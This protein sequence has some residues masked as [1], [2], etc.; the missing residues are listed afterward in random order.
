MRLKKDFMKKFKRIF[1]E[2]S[3]VCNLSCSFCPPTCR[4]A[5]VMSLEDFERV[6]KRL[7]G[8][9]DNVYLHVKGEPLLHP[10]FEGILNLCAQ[11]KKKI[12]ITTNGTLIDK[13]G[14]H[15]LKNPAVRLVSVSLQSHEKTGDDLG[16]KTYLD[17][18]LSFVKRGLKE[19]DSLFALRLWNFEDASLV[20]NGKNQKTLDYIEEFLDLSS[21]IT[22]TDP[23]TNGLK[24]PD[25]VYI[26]KGV[27]FDWPSLSHDLVAT[28][29]TCYGLRRQI[30]ILS[31]GEV[32]PCCL[33]ADGVIGL[34]NILDQSF[35]EIVMSPKAVKI[36]TSLE[37]NKL[38][39]PLC[40]RCDYRERFV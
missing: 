9:G 2:I 30:A 14:D 1:I 39:E 36:R 35:E 28:S 32:V 11:Y 17:N 31:T 7:E 26:S 15:I 12:N 21:P 10:D 22:V 23:K 19:T 18:I 27:E 34:G 6:M 24:L 16:Y 37:N 20:A 25:K 13:Q 38:I 3:N 40:Q 4:P 33:D 8:H 5:K 29:G